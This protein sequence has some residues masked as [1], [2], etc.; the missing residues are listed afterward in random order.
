MTAKSIKYNNFNFQDTNWRT[1]DIIYRNLPTKVL[2][3]EPLSRRD[4]FRLVNTYYSDKQISISGTVTSDSEANLRILVD[5]MKKAL[6]ENEANLEITDGADTVSWIATVGSVSIPEEFYNITTLPYKISFTCQPFGKAT[7]ITTSTASIENTSSLSATIVI[8]GS[9]YPRPVIRWTVSGSPASD[10]TGISITN[11]TTGDTLTATGL[12]LSGDGDYF[13]IDTEEMS[14]VQNTGSGEV[15]ID[16]T[17]VF[18]RFATSTNSYA[19]TIVGGGA[20][21]K[22]N[23]SITY[24]A[25]YL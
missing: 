25:S 15:E 18:P 19:V 6:S 13:E 9:A 21:K 4:G 20:T 10:I 3:I 5:S 1:K 22:L 12:A 2:D 23:Q 17:G 14:A 24:Y 11:N 8:A 16:F 7:T